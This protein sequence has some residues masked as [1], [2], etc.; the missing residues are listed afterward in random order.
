ME[1]S[2][3]VKKPAIS[4]DSLIGKYLP[5]D[6]SD[7]YVCET[8]SGKELNPDDVLIAFWTN[9]TAWVSA[10]FRLR[11]FLVKFVGLKG[12]GERN[13]EELEKC[14]RTGGTYGFTS[15]VAKDDRETVMLLTDSHLNAYMSV[16]VEGGT[17][18]IA[19]LVHFKNR[20]GRMYFFVI[21]PFHGLIVR[22]MLRIAVAK[23]VAAITGKVTDPRSV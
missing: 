20:L 8:P 3:S 17:A 21:R 6:Y 15:V 18:A 1:S 16:R 7:V 19:T 23:T 5:A 10:L 4:P 9:S 22:R 13:A 11:N 12:S 2:V 14:I